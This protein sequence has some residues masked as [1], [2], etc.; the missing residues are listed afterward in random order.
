MHPIPL[1]SL[2]HHIL[3]LPWQLTKENE[4]WI[5]TNKQTKPSHHGSCGVSHGVTQHILLSTHL[6]LQ[7]LIAMG[8]WCGWRPL[9]SATLS[10]LDPHWDS[11]GISWCHHVSWRSAGPALS[12]TPTV[13]RWGG[14]TQ[15]LDLG[16]VGSWAGQPTS[17]AV[18]TLSEAA[19]LHP[20]H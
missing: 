15:P 1:V 11:S 3:P 13:H 9:A 4:N 10:I 16:L 17:S 7:M 18:L 5:K 2:S 14:I 19:L 8:H 20:S 12:W 6:Y